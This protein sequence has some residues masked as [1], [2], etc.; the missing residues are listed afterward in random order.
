MALSAVR[1]TLALLR[2]LA[3]LSGADRRVLLAAALWLPAVDLGLR[4]VGFARVRRW[5]GTG[6]SAGPPSAPLSPER[7]AEAEA[8]ARWVTV[9]ARHHLWPMTC[10]RRALVIDRMLARRGIPAELSIGVRKG[11]EGFR[12]H[13]W[14]ECGGRPLFEP[15]AV[16]LRYASLEI[17][18]SESA[19]SRRAR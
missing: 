8:V 18:S 13:A 14:I 5:L 2:R 7:R 12:A 1:R 10:L 11:E 15:E 6:R 4:T 16:E 19:S 17:P 9:A 3:R